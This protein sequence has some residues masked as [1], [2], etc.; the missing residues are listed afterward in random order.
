M[1]YYF[2]PKNDPVRR[3]DYD[4]DYEDDIP[5][6]KPFELFIDFILSITTF[7]IKLLYVK[8]TNQKTK[9][10]LGENEAGHAG[11]NGRNFNNLK[12]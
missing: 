6:C 9:G 11:A 10:S 5:R 1:R 2:N 3:S 4:Y 8:Q 7:F 12:Q